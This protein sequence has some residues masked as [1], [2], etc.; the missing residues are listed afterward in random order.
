MDTCKF[1]P[2][3]CKNECKKNGNVRMIMRKNLEKHLEQCPNR[4]YK[5]QSCGKEGTFAYAKK[6]HEAECEKKTISCTNSECN[7]TMERGELKKHIE[8]DCDYAVISCRYKS[9]GC[10]VKM[11]RK[12]MG[13]H[14][15]DDKAHLHQALNTVVKLQSSLDV[16][17]EKSVCETKI[18]CRDYEKGKND[19]KLFFSQPFYTSSDGYRMQ[20]E[21]Y[22]NGY[23]DGKGTHVSVYVNILKGDNDAVLNWPFVGKVTFKLLNQLADENHYF[24]IISFDRDHD[25]RVE[26]GLGDNQFIHHLQLPYDPLNKT[27]YLKDD[28]LY[29]KVSVEVDKPWL[30]CTA[31]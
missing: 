28:S 7:Q 16:L 11:K 8:N 3:P 21:I 13:V 26:Y 14:E 9:F 27:E 19:E 18:I 4:N 1:T 15:Q 30:E 2:I 10:D 5:C 31:K 17:K 23:D 29:F 12:D 20:V 25:I 6:I 24:K 22:P